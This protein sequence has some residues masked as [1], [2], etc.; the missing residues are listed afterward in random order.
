MI[1]LNSSLYVLLCSTS[2]SILIDFRYNLRL[3]HNKKRLDFSLINF[4]RTY[5]VKF[6]FNV[7]L[8]SN[9]EYIS[10][11]DLRSYTGGR[12]QEELGG[13]VSILTSQFTNH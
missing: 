2:A 8:L 13:I 5:N 11:L 10:I 1:R 3:E 9:L 7:R 12:V 4:L 6:L